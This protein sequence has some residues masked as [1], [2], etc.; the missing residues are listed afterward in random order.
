MAKEFLRPIYKKV[1]GTEFDA[2]SFEN[3]M[4]MQK[5]I[6]LL[7]EAGIRVGD[8]DFLWY[9][10]G[11]YSQG[12]QDDILVLNNTQDAKINYSL[13][14]E[15]ILKRLKEVFNM[16]VAYSRSAWVECLASLQYLKAYYYPIGTKDDTIIEE[17]KRRKG[18]LN[19]D[20]LN[21]T[22]LEQLDYIL[23]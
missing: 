1:Y 4:E 22:A 10:H 7:Q 5:M 9:K 14:A 6:F 13:D 11:P 3:R 20:E 12:L 16:H 23:G 21:K 15:E 17:L 18:H 8:Y 2:T 19:N